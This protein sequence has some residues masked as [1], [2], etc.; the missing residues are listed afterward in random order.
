MPDPAASACRRS[1]C[2][3]GCLFAASTTNVSRSRC[4]ACPPPTQRNA[5]HVSRVGEFH[6]G[7]SGQSTPVAMP[8]RSRTACHTSSARSSSTPAIEETIATE[9]MSLA[10]AP[11]LAWDARPRRLRC[12]WTPRRPRPIRHRRSLVQSSRPDHF[13]FDRCDRALRSSLVAQGISNSCA[14]DRRFRNA[15][16]VMPRMTPASGSSLDG[17][18]SRR[19]CSRQILP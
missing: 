5:P 19:R 14:L 6:P 4:P 12:S 13:F 3:S 2:P 16:A 11:R 1:T 10:T 15:A 17:T 8:S 9:D 7:S 18:H